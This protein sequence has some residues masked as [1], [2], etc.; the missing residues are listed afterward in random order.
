[1][2]FPTLFCNKSLGS[3]ASLDGRYPE[4]RVIHFRHLLVSLP[5]LLLP[6]VLRISRLRIWIWMGSSLILITVI[7]IV[8]I[9]LLLKEDFSLLMK[10]YH[11]NHVWTGLAPLFLLPFSFTFTF[12]SLLLRHLIVL[13]MK[14]EA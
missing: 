10:Q 2:L 12:L 5:P 7:F 13:F 14:D 8:R 4:S 6:L 3:L 9:T 11:D 1:M